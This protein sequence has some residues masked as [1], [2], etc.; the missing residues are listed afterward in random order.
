MILVVVDN[1]GKVVVSKD[2]WSLVQ[3]GSGWG[4]GTPDESQPCKINGR[5]TA[6]APDVNAAAFKTAAIVYVLFPSIRQ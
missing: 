5:A 2:G 1:I 6:G 3:F 4:R